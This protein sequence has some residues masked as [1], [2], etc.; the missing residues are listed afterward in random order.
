MSTE[1]GKRY[2]EDQK[3]ELVELFRQSGLN[4][5]RF[6]KE[7]NVSYPTLK[8]WLGPQPAKTVEFVEVGEAEPN[9]ARLSVALPNGIWAEFPLSAEKSVVASW[10]RE[11]K[12][13]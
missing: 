5:S 8:R 13:C 11:L 3:K 4:A 2:T 6:C 12:A 7:M 10:I 1:R 9:D